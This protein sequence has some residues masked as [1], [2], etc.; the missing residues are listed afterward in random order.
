MANELSTIEDTLTARIAANL[1]QRRDEL[2]LSLRALATKSGVSPS[3][4]SDIERGAKSPTVS[5][6]GGLAEALDVPLATLIG[7]A[8]PRGRIEVV[9]RAEQAVVADPTGVKRTSFGPPVA[10]SRVEFSSYV[11]PPR[12]VAGPFPAH[13][14]GTVEHIHLAAGT[15]RVELGGESVVLETGDSCSCRADAP[16]LFDNSRGKTRALLY[17]V[18]ER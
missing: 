4:I 15:L 16:H 14:A 11:V 7:A 6:L 18:V 17:L 3:M 8:A 10:G 5:T 9:H 13:A 12:V 1:K 2:G